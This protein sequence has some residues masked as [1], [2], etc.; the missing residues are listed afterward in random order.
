ME[1]SSNGGGFFDNADE[2]LNAIE[3]ELGPEAAEA[4]RLSREVRLHPREL[5]DSE[6]REF[7]TALDPVLHDLRMSG[8]IVPDVRE[9]PWDDD[10]DLVFGWIESAS[11]GLGI[12][13]QLDLSAAER[14]ADV[15]D[16][17]QEWEVEELAAEGRPATWPECPE[18]PDSHP[19]TPEVRD[20]RA[21]WCCPKS[22][23]VI[24][25]IGALGLSSLVVIVASG[26]GGAG[27]EPPGA[28]R[29]S[30]AWRRRSRRPPPRRASSPA[31]GTPT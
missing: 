30:R 5:T 11:S 22:G 12:R 2:L 10:P 8:A 1:I 6:S 26:G 7:R 25:P 21:L 29:G 24:H 19:L 15:A 13:I 17:V 4:L 14:L 28:L 16:Q 27:A 23:H 3:S 18:H 9:Q 20:S 31:A